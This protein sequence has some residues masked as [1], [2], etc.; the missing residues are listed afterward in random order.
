MMSVA[1][2]HAEWL[3]LIDINGPFLS[4]EVLMRAFPQ[5]LD[6]LD[7]DT[8]RMIRSACLEWEDSFTGSGQ[9]RHPDQSVHRAW[10][11]L[12]LKRLLEYG[13]NV[14]VE[15]QGIPDGVCANVAEHGETLRPDY[16]VANPNS[17]AGRLESGKPRLLIKTYP[18]NQE[19]EKPIAKARWKAS[20]ATRM[21]ELLHATSAQ[22]GMVTNGQQWMLVNAPRGE[23]AG[24][25]TWY[26]N[27]WLEE[28]ST[29]QAFRSLLHARRFFGVAEAQT[30]EALLKESAQNRQEVTDR[31]GYQVRRALEVFVQTI[32]R[33][34]KDRGR[35]LLA[36]VSEKQLYEAALAVM[37][38]LVFL[39]SA[40]EKELLLLGDE[41]YDR[42]YA[43]ST[44]AAKLREEADQTGEEVL[45][46]RH[47]A[48]A[49]LLAT[50][51]AVHSG[52]EHDRLRLSAYGGSLFDPD[53]F[54]FLEGRERGSHWRE[55]EASPIPID[56][57]T[58]L[59]LLEAL[60]FLE[61]KV[62][63]GWETRRLSFRSLDVEQIGH[64]YEGLLDHTAKRA[65]S[66]VLGLIGAK[67]LEPEVE[68]KELERRRERSE[69]A[70]AENAMAEDALVGYLNEITL[71]SETT[72]RKA[73][74]AGAD[75]NDKLDSQTLHK[76]LTAC[77][78]NEG[79]RDRV[80]P[81]LPLLRA[82]MRGLP[83]VIAAGSVYVTDGDDR[84]S[85][86]THYTP[87]S[88]TDPIV[89]HTLEPLVYEGVAEGRPKDQWKLKPAAELLRLK[90]C[91]LAMGSGA[92]L[93]QTCRYL[94]ERLVESWEEVER[95]NPGKVV[96][97]PDGALSDARADECPIPKDADERLTVARRIVA[98]R[99]LYGVDVNPMAVEMAKLSL[100]LVTLQKNR[101]FTFLDHALRCGDSLLGVT[102]VEQIKYFNLKAGDAGATQIPFA[103]PYLKEQLAVVN[104]KRQ[105]LES[106]A[107]ND[108]ADV[109]RKQRMLAEAEE[110]LDRVRFFGDL[111]VGDSLR[112]MNKLG[113][114]RSRRPWQSDD[115]NYSEEERE[116]DELTDEVM[117]VFSLLNEARFMETEELREKAAALLSHRKPFHWALE[118]PE[119]FSFGVP[120]SGGAPAEAAKPPEGGTP[121]ERTTNAGFDAIVGN[122]PFIGG[123][124]ITGALGTD[125][126]NFLVEYLASGKRGSADLSAYFFLRAKSLLRPG[127]CFGLVATNTIAQGDT[128][129]VGLDQITA[130]AGV[131]YRAL[132]S[133]PWPG[134]ASLEVAYVWL[135]NG[136]DWNG[137]RVL[138][139]QSVSGI[140]PFLVPASRVSGKP[141]QLA[142]NADKS[143]IGSYVLG[144]GFVLTP[145]EA[146]GLIVKDERNRDV[147]FPYLNGEDLNSRPDQSPSRRVINF[148]D[149]PLDRSAKG[150][151]FDADEKEREGW[152]KRGRVPEDY[153]DAVATDYPACLKIVVEKVK[154]ERDKNNRAVRRERWWQYAERAPALYEAIEGMER[155]LA[156]PLVSKHLT[157][158]WQSVNAVFSHMLGVIAAE[159]NTV[160]ALTQNTFHDEWARSQGS[161]LETRMRYTPSDCFET[162]PFPEEMDNLEEIGERYYLHRQSVML[163]RQEGLTKTYNRL[164]DPSEKSV[165]IE[166]LRQLH[167]EM[168]QHVAEAYGWR[169]L[170]LGHG[171]HQTK[172]G[173]RFTISEAAR[174]E[175][176]DRLLAL[177][178]ERYAEEEKLGLHEKGKKKKAVAKKS[179]KSRE[180]ASEGAPG[181]VRRQPELF[182]KSDQKDL[183]ED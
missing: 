20:P 173:V 159:R 9:Q 115:E 28:K 34:D 143:F 26:A 10:I 6:G 137:E 70:M 118:F 181:G 16:V 136:A 87:R 112:M 108:I 1:R 152:L 11:E 27:L 44:L 94:A 93:V 39:L 63:G 36:G 49:R 52:I 43:V 132:P 168:D 55:T 100:W 119:V 183:L 51:R 12:V 158:A 167:V 60:Q 97:A 163:A 178:H 140:T 126:R 25:I 104:A 71:R 116:S 147:L 19:L 102:D 46:R 107:V 8:A 65:T 17:L 73:I 21:M 40:E 114:D 92:F 127:G 50:F 30:I 113:R 125:Y 148:R 33:I 75:P 7:T 72:L 77:D 160:F 91:D 165:D 59:H 5:G 110:A 164:H 139:E 68:L 138:S 79:L 141:H 156:V 175:V 170:D 67:N 53:R 23:S 3:N 62:P 58:V 2:Q 89:R 179:A 145:E 69:K 29:L 131:I 86:G 78:N 96:I 42:H 176:L 54:P 106:F 84:R 31:L 18:A 24:F 146:Q 172:Q 98:D 22:L 162:F 122:P 4:V 180:A 157:C 154:P 64:V 35:A 111:L 144:M 161:S 103:G 41:I 121:N 101:P 105:E 123:Q 48:W 14:L 13:D 88:L 155:V 135:R 169:D 85:T 153:P 99:C 130:N 90:V 81:F 57:R 38:R 150:S 129:E 133:T 177:N 171:F 124:K 174:V 15:G 134:E 80:L 149:W 45:E 109:E 120:P 76:L 142:A 61:M 47:D 82:D 117:R 32:D 128:R 56:N 95:A 74:A 166:R 151:W 37:M 83:V 66:P 182:A